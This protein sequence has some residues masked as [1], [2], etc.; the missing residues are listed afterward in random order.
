MTRRNFGLLLAFITLIGLVFV[1]DRLLPLERFGLTPRTL[2]GLIGVAMMPFLHANYAHLIGN[3]V[4][5]VV[6]LLLVMATNRAPVA[7]TVSI[8]LLSGVLIWLFARGGNHIGAS[9][10]VFGLA[11]FLIAGGY[12]AKSAMALI[13]AVITLATYGVTLLSGVLPVD[14]RVSWDGHLA[15]AVAGVLVAQWQRRMPVAR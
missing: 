6:L 8:T 14:A 15:G 12:Q 13:A 5:L 2:D 9:A 7:T 11:T 4:P 10:L 1:A 3:S